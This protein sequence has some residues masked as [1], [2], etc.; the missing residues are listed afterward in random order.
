LIPFCKKKIP[1]NINDLTFPFP[2]KYR[3]GV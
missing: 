3:G 2:E 1:L